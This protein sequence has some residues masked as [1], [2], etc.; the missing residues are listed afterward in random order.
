MKR[1]TIL[2]LLMGWWLSTNAQAPLHV[3]EAEGYNIPV[4]NFKG[5]EPILNRS[6]DTVYVYNFWAT[7]C[8]PCVEE[9]PAFLK[10][11]STMRLLPKESFGQPVRVMLVSIDMKSQ[12]K[13][14]LIPFLKTRNITAPVVVLS[15]PDANVW[16]DKIDKNWGGTIPATLFV[17]KGQKTFHEGQLTYDELYQTVDT[18]R[19]Q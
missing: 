14:K 3:L 18:I 16:I 1:L 5:L 10:F 4:Y 2:V 9:L 7:W 15:D 8:I 17:Y 13:S 12:L 19:K 6:N 11:D